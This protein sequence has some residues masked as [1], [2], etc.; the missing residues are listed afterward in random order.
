MQFNFVVSTNERAVRLWK[1]FGDRRLSSRSIFPSGEWL[2]RRLHHVP[3][4]TNR[5]IVTAGTESPLLAV[6]CK[7]RM[8]H[9]GPKLVVATRS[10]S[11]KNIL[12]FA[13]RGALAR[14]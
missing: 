9:L 6:N 1:S 5:L 4:L 2:C 8:L 14:W 7:Q 10:K 3:E 13:G 11:V 12:K